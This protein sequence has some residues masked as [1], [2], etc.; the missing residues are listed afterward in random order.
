MT[1]WQGLR[2]AD[3]ERGSMLVET[4]F[5]VV[6][7]LLPLFYLV[8]T[9]GRL[10]AGAYAVSAAARE[11]GRTFVA[12]DDEDTGRA[13]AQTAAWLVMDSHGFG[14]EDG[15]VALTCASDPCLT[16]GSTVRTDATVQVSLPLIPDFLS[17][18]VPTSVTLTSSHVSPVDDYREP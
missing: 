6:L 10:Q 3:A 8:G 14:Q 7:V 18:A 17:G 16:P 5:L 15:S 9:L 1:G 2:A 13:A 12:G 4:V 11:A